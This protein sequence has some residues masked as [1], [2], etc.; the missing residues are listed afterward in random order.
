[1]TI[2]SSSTLAPLQIIWPLI[3]LP[4]IPLILLYALYSWWQKNRDEKGK[5]PFESQPRP[6]GWSLQRRCENLTIDWFGDLCMLIVVGTRGIFLQRTAREFSNHPNK[7][8]CTT[9][10]R[11][12]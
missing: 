3:L 1:M 10:N 2:L 5:S 12:Q 7:F 4:G 8:C 9:A 11:S 6:A